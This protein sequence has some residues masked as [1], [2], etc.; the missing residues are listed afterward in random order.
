MAE[1]N[2]YSVIAWTCWFLILRVYL[3]FLLCGIVVSIFCF[4]SY[5]FRA[6]YNIQALPFDNLK[7]ERMMITSYGQV[8]VD[9]DLFASFLWDCEINLD[10]SQLQVY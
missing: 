9:Q 5:W 1:N 3:S 6:L 10:F 2:N 4:H 7:N 8:N